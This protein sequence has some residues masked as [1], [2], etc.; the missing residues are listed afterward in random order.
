MAIRR[1]MRMAQTRRDALLRAMADVRRAEVFALL[2]E[3][4]NCL[5]SNNARFSFLVRR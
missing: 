4:S 3:L 2:W 5:E 1:A